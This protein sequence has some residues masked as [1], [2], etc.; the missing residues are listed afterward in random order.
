[1]Q[2]PQEKSEKERSPE[3]AVMV[4]D[5]PTRLFHWL[6]VALVITCLVTGR[7]GGSYMGTHM[8]SGYAVLTLLLFRLTWGVVGGH[9]ARFATF[10]RG[11]LSVLRY[12]ANLLGKDA[13]RYLGHNPLGGWSVLAMLV[14]LAL[15][16]STGL[17]ANDDIFTEGPL[18]PLVSKAASDV[19]TRIHKIND[20]VLLFLVVVHVLAVFFYLIVKGDNLIKPMITGVKHWRGKAPSA[21]GRIWAAGL[22]LGLSCAVVYFIVR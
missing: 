19:L 15:Q 10:V 16:A 8:F 22:I 6:V 3:R 1:M 17:F 21:G 20:G 13:P 12:A 18:Y 7:I 9:H 2:K 11:P 5:L 4:W 14:A